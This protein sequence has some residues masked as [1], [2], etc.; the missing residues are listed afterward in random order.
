MNEPFD[1]KVRGKTEEVRVEMTPPDLMES[2]I[3]VIAV[4]VR[5]GNLQ[6]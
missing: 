5:G 4:V 2:S 6:L 3:E 1:F